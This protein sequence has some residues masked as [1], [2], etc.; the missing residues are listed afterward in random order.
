MM[1]LSSNNTPKYLFY[2][3]RQTLYKVLFDVKIKDSETGTWHEG[4]VYQNVS[5]E[6]SQVYCRKFSDFDDRWE[7][8]EN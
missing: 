5:S 1:E 7:I 8:F 3:P 4:V 6:D 2:I